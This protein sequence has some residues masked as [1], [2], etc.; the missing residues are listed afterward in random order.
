[1]KVGVQEQEV[2]KLYVSTLRL[3]WLTTNSRYVK[4]DLTVHK[5][6]NYPNMYIFPCYKKN[7]Y[8]TVNNVNIFI[9]ILSNELLWLVL[10]ECV[11]L[12]NIDLPCSCFWW[13]QIT[14]Q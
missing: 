3:S 11:I 9:L 13:K 12:E 6:W 4:D 10:L 7:M 14:S 8:K 2:K 1:M 5:Y